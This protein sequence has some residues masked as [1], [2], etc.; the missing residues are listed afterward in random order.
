MVLRVG[1]GLLL[2]QLRPCG[3]GSTGADADA[4]NTNSDADRVGSKGDVT[5]LPA[6]VWHT[7]TAGGGRIATTGSVERLPSPFPSTA[8]ARAC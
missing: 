2:L 4:L 5:R 6:A 7:A 3:G 8:V 1:R